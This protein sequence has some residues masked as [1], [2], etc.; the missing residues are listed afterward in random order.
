[1]P[2]SMACQRT[3]YLFT[4]SVLTPRS[5]GIDQNIAL[6]DLIITGFYGWANA[7]CFIK[8]VRSERVGNFGEWYQ[9]NALIEL[10]NDNYF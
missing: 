6:T 3:V 2:I 1:M 10:Q 7:N 9:R 8:N 4:V 5:E